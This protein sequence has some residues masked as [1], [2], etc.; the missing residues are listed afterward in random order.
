[1][2]ARRDS[3]VALIALAMFVVGL[4]A[5]VAWFWIGSSHL[6]PKVRGMEDRA[7]GVIEHLDVPQLEPRDGPRSVSPGHSR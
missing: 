2:A 3:R 6:V 5:P 1:M 7:I 4:V